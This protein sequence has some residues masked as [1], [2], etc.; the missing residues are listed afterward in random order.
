[1]TYTS[2]HWAVQLK[3]TGA[4]HMFL[5][6]ARDYNPDAFLPS[7]KKKAHI[8][9]DAAKPVAETVRRSSHQL[10]ITSV[11]GGPDAIQLLKHLH[12]N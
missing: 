3:Y 1:M 6:Y 7:K 2:L 9:I 4:V 8:A 11:V 12:S 10:Q 5:K